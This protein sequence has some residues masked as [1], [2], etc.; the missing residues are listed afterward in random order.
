MG[1]TLFWGKLKIHEHVLTRFP[2]FLPTFASF[3]SPLFKDGV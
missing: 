3:S 2:V 1:A